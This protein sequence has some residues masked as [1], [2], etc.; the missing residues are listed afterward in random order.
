[1]RFSILI[2]YGGLM[3]KM[4]EPERGIAL[5]GEA[6]DLVQLNEEIAADLLS[7]AVLW[8]NRATAFDLLEDYER[9]IAAYKTSIDLHRQVHPE[10]SPDLAQ[11][12]ANVGLTY[13]IL[14][15]QDQAIAYV[16][17]AVEMQRQLLGESHPQYLLAAF[18]LG[19]LQYNG[20]DLESAI[21]NISIAVENA[22]SAYP[23]PHLYTG[24]FKQRLAEL[25][26]E[27]GQTEKAKDLA[28]SSLEIFNQL[29]GV[30]EHWIAAA[31]QISEQADEEL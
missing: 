17:E 25:N 2:D 1:M 16:S 18:N 12:L 6:L 9:S 31:R 7:Q 14:G 23:P 21:T 15:D 5:T 19:S 11:A 30:P 4:D 29:E 28:D 24:R 22:D 27:I 3:P 20:G 10:G 13:E 8:N 26:L